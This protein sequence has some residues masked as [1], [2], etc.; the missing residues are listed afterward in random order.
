MEILLVRL[1]ALMMSFGA[2]M[3]D[4]RGVIQPYPGLSMLTG[5]FGNALGLHHRDTDAL[6]RLQKRLRYAV[7]CDR[8][9]TKVRDFQT[10]DLGQGFLLDDRAWTTRGQLE[11]RAG[12]SKTGTHIRERDYWAGAVYTLAVALSPG[13]ETPTLKELEHV[14]RFPTRPLFIGRKPCIPSGPLSLGIVEGEE[15]RSALE[16]CPLHPDAPSTTCEVWWPVEGEIYDRT[17]SSQL[18][19]DRRDWRNQIHTGQRWVAHSTLTVVT[20]EEGG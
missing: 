12:G 16:S 6:E 18:V 17:T 7:R 19:S 15:L 1:E 4:S 11:S 2:P 8:K 3:V 14:L 13:S 9:G 5:L 20:E 10:V